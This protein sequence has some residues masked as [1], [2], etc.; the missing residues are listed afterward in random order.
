MNQVTFSRDFRVE[1][2]SCDSKNEMKL[3]YILKKSQ[4]ISMEHCDEIG[5]GRT[6]LLGINKVFL[7]AKIN[8]NVINMP[9]GGDRLKIETIP[10]FPERL[11]YQRLN[12]FYNEH[13]E[14]MIDVDSRWILV[15]TQSGRI[16]RNIPDEFPKDAFNVH[17][18]LED[19]RIHKVDEMKFAERVK[20]RY[21]LTD[22][23]HHLNN[24]AYADIICNCVED[25]LVSGSIDAFSIIY[26]HEAKFSQSVDLYKGCQNDII[27]IKGTVDNAS[28]FESSLKII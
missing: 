1:Y 13:G 4:E 26:H 15:D 8:L 16:T 6:F 17:Q 21:S 2:S 25:R 18:G 5:I 28:C 22:T 27:Y 19:F 20:V 7:L 24:A 11:Q 10:Y 14:L 3:S 23:N 12:R 9:K